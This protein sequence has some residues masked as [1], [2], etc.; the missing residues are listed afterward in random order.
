MRL[1][2]ICD[3]YPPKP[4]GGIGTYLK[5]IAEGMVRAGHE[6]TVVGWGGVYREYEQS[7][8]SVVELRRLPFLERIS[9]YFLRLKLYMYLRGKAKAGKID[10]LE[11]PDYFGWLPFK[12]SYC[13]VVVRLHLS[14]LIITHY[15]GQKCSRQIGYYEKKTLSSNSC[16]VGVSQFALSETIRLFSMQPQQSE[17]IYYPVTSPLSDKVFL[18][19]LSG[20]YL[21]FAGSISERKGAVTLARAAVDLLCKYSDVSLVYAG[22]ILESGI[23]DRIR[24][25]SG[26]LKGD[27][28]IF[29]GRIP[30][31]EVMALMKKASVFVFPSKLETFGLVIAEAMLNGTP[32]V[33]CNC[34]PCPEFVTHGKTGE[35][36]GVD[37]DR[38][39]VDSVSRILD[40]PAYAANLSWAG[41]EYISK[42]FSLEMAVSRNLAMYESLLAG[43]I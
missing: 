30:R 26:E 2:Y 42:E 9:G 19:R 20:R 39:I 4:H 33:C 3:E 6:V 31:E 13:P 23:E 38:A 32:T 15:A 17:V 8:V 28:V 40:D 43:G 14:T 21:L 27:R 36:V 1:C 29:T 18:P 34:G 24:K 7:G 37:D 11:V 41:S 12:F 10:I 35:L 25:I 5:D 22:P 16:W